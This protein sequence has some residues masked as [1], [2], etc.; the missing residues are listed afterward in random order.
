[1]PK[2]RPLVFNIAGGRTEDGPGIR[3]AAFLK[4]CPLQCRWCHNPESQNAVQEFMW[5]EKKCFGC[6]RCAQACPVEAIDFQKDRL[7]LET[8]NCKGCGRC[9]EACPGEALTGVGEEYSVEAL[10]E[11]LKRDKLFFEVSGGGVTFSGGEPLLYPEYV[12]AAAESLKKEKID[13]CIETCGFFNYASFAEY[14]LPFTD[15][16]LFDLKLMSDRLHRKYTGQGN[17]LILENFKRLC[18]E[19]VDITPRTPL[20]PG[21]TDSQENLAKIRQ[22]LLP[23]HLEEKHELLPYN[24]AGEMKRRKLL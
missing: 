13:I 5:D 7:R 24:S 4:G 22:F 3:T 14:V 12:G 23:Y 18:G 21:I 11:R 2:R 20:I 15:R 9:T 17:T 8:A 10:A 16:V 6:G 19:K 1:M